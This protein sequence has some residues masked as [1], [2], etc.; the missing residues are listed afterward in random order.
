MME[1]TSG[2]ANGGE[3]GI[4]NA[5]DA[6]GRKANSDARRSEHLNSFLD[7]FLRVLR[8]LRVTDSLPF[9]QE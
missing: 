3:R 4:F 1:C 5:K 9:K 7:F 6:K 8:V 2:A